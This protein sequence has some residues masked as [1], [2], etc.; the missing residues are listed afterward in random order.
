MQTSQK[1][2]QSKHGFTLLEL[3][4]VI[5]IIGLI[6]AGISAGQ[7][8]IDASKRKQAVTQLE[9]YKTAINGFRLAYGALPG[10]I[11]NAY[12]YWGAACDATEDNCNGNGNKNIEYT[13]GPSANESLRSW[14]HLYLAELIDQEYTGIGQG[15]GNEAVP[16]VNVPLFAFKN[17][18]GIALYNT[19]L[20]GVSSPARLTFRIGLNATNSSPTSGV[21][22]PESY[23]YDSKFDDGKP[24]QGIIRSMHHVNGTPQCRTSNNALLA[25]YP[26]SRTTQEECTFFWQF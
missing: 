23:Y 20:Y 21:T 18:L 19:S 2:S 13:S 12:D 9:Q 17:N 1:K 6:V 3:S 15:T 8:L 4:I 26:L 5:V 24:L 22:A 16:N 25:E 11:N 7:S 10:D 14:Q